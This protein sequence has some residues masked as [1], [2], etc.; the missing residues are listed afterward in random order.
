MQT[1]LPACVCWRSSALF[2]NHML[3]PFAKLNC[4]ND[5]LATMA[6]WLTELC[7]RSRIL[8]CWDPFGSVSKVNDKYTT[9]QGDVRCAALSN[10]HVAALSHTMQSCKN[11]VFFVRCRHL[12]PYASCWWE[13]AYTLSTTAPFFVCLECPRTGSCHCYLS[14]TASPLYIALYW[15]TSEASNIIP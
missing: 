9:I 14:C 7:Y 1:Y 13:G 2:S 4:Y 5:I 15:V 6:F 10:V 3:T 8:P 11:H 12:V